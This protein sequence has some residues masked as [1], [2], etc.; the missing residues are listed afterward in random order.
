MKE[1]GPARGGVGVK[2]TSGAEGACFAFVLCVVGLDF[3]EVR[4]AEPCLPYRMDAT[5]S[6]APCFPAYFRERSMN[7][8][9]V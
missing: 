7:V 1:D 6:R 9:I 3:N 2:G 8:L 5:H 4:N